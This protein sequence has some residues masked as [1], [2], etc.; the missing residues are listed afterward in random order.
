[1]EVINSS[2]SKEAKDIV[3]AT[4][5]EMM[6]KLRDQAEDLKRMCEANGYNMAV[7]IV[8]QKETVI[9]KDHPMK[10]KLP[11]G[12]VFCEAINM[13]Y[14]NTKQTTE[15]AMMAFTKC[16]DA[17]D[18]SISN[19]VSINSYYNGHLEDTLKSKDIPKEIRVGYERALKEI[20][21]AILRGEIS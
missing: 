12:D 13:G 15:K 1:M 6:K 11:K 14:Y 21:N 20:K 9:D 16:K 18:D 3:K 10:D 8:A 2:T 7:M 5:S 17:H 4:M 19:N